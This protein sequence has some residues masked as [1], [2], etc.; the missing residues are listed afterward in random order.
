MLKTAVFKL[1]RNT[2]RGQ[3]TLGELIFPD[4]R[5]FHTLEDTVRGW[6]IKDAGNTAIPFGLYKMM[7]SMSGKFKRKMA[8]I[9]TEPNQYELKGSGISFKGI[10]VHGG[11]DHQ[12]TWGCIVVAKNRMSDTTVQGSAEKEFTEAVEKLIADGFECYIDIKNLSQLK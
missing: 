3:T 1:N 11:N 12:D 7:V 5:K 10:R 9:Y 2:Y 4:K 8:M 6:G